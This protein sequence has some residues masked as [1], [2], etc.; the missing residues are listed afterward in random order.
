MLLGFIPYPNMSRRETDA[1]IDRLE[2]G[3]DAF[4]PNAT[5]DLDRQEH[6]VTCS[7]G[8]LPRYLHSSVERFGVV[9]AFRPSISNRSP[10]YLP[11]ST[12]IVLSQSLL[13]RPQV[14]ID[15]RGTLC[16]NNADI[17]AGNNRG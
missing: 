13:P 4:C 2:N 16:H 10:R 3:D 14:V 17:L 1:W 15:Y 9:R 6:N 5:I 12:I 11:C 7:P 8:Y